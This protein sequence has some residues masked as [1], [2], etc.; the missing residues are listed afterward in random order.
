MKTLIASV[1][2]ALVCLPGCSAEHWTGRIKPESSVKV[3]AG[4]FGK[5]MEI[6]NSKDVKLQMAGSWDPDSGQ[7][8]LSTFLLEDMSSPVI[9]ADSD[10]M[11]YIIEAQRVQVEYQRQIGDNIKM[12]LLAGGDA[13][14]SF[15]TSIPSMSSTFE[16]PFG[17]GS[18]QVQPVPPAPAPKQDDPKDEPSPDD[19]KEEP[20]SEPSE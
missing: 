20:P 19:A 7:L 18:V 1:L 11:R 3:S 9:N 13:A 15:L 8:N 6:Y 10:R 2:M 14:R 17:R 4:P 12:A 5:S 16:N